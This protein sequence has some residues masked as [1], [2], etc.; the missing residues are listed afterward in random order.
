MFSTPFGN[1][2]SC[3]MD[4]RSRAADGA[5]SVG[6]STYVFPVA[7]AMGNIQSGIIAGKLNGAVVVISADQNSQSKKLDVTKRRVRD[8]YSY[9]YQHIHPVFN[10]QYIYF[11]TMLS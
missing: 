4:A 8:T 3:R 7:M 6:L 10:E 9:Q 11:S 1:P 5:F 2:K